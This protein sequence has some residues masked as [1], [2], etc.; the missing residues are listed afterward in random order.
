MLAGCTPVPTVVPSPSR[1]P[2]PSPSPSP[3]PPAAQ[4]PALPPPVVQPPPAAPATPGFAEGVA[5]SCAGRPAAAA[6]LALLTTNGVLTSTSGV[7][8]N[9][10]PLCAGTWQYTV[11]TVT[12][13]E[14]L[15]VITEGAPDALRLVAAGT[16]VCSTVG[17]QAPAGILS[18][19]HCR[20][21]P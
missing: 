3:P 19:A 20:S 8:V 13:R 18:V 10:G 1:A 5:V 12:G 14:P 16:E 6:V 9:V 11:L 4:P 15:Q 21:L 17:T 2:S 7:T